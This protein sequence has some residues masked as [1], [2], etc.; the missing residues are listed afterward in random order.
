MAAASQPHL[1]VV[2]DDPSI[3]EGLV[4]AL[5]GSYTVHT[6]ATG[7]A[8]CAILRTRPVA[9]IVLDAILGD[10]HGLDLVDRFRGLSQAPIL[11]LTG[12]GSE[13]LAIRALRAKVAEYLKKPVDLH[14]LYRA[15]ARLLPS[16]NFP[17]D[18]MTHAHLHLAEDA[19]ERFTGRDLARHVGLSERQL[20][21]RFQD[22]YGKT[23]RRYLSERRLRQA[24]DMLRT[25]RLGI[26]QI[27]AELGAP[28]LPAFRREFTRLFGV[29][30]LAF[31][32]RAQREGMSPALR[33]STS[34]PA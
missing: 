30:P 11:L 26:K 15:L 24:A 19:E 7:D 12:Y 28:S 22:A 3:R 32:A 31:R 34:P 18:P 20:R 10:E 1:L 27:A 2:D 14:E 8:A 6:S 9:G 21:R 13:E 33:A 17:P 16:L 5:A 23:P 4:L 25:T 29:T